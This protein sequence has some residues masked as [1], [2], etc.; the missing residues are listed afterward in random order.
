MDYIRRFFGSP[1][2]NDRQQCRETYRYHGNDGKSNRISIPPNEDVQRRGFHVLTDPLHMHQYFEHQM[3]EVLKNFGFQGFEDGFFSEF[4]KIPGSEAEIKLSEKETSA[5]LREQNPDGSVETH[6]TVRD[7]EGNEELTVCYKIGNKEYC[8][9]KKKDK[10]G[11][12]EVTENFVNKNEN[13]KNEFF[14]PK[15]SNSNMEDQ[16]KK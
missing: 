9:I 7:N 16:Q 10:H 13:E 14:K 15:F 5:E 6:H 3:N 1:N 12:E 8:T 4:H 11:R 2:P